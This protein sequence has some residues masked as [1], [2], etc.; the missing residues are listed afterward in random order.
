MHGATITHHKTT[1]I[2]NKRKLGISR[3][4]IIKKRTG[5]LAGLR[6]EMGCGG[7]G[8]GDLITYDVRTVS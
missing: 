3:F 6:G 2:R 1:R 5:H 4:H 8:D 7:Y